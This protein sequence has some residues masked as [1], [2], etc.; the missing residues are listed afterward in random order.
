MSEIVRQAMQR[1][2]DEI[3]PGLEILCVMV[4]RSTLMDESDYC[5]SEYDAGI[6]FK[7]EKFVGIMRG[8]GWCCENCVALQVYAGVVAFCYDL[9]AK[10]AVNE[11]YGRSPSSDELPAVSKVEAEHL[12]R[13]FNLKNE[14]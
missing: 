2:A 3:C 11:K 4:S 8:K 12:E 9:D 13:C 7:Y 6:S 14:D 5:T 10:E 1:R